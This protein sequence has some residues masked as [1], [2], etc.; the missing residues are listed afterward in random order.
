MVDLLDE[1]LTPLQ[2]P[3]LTELEEARAGAW[4]YR[5]R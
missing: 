1:D 4:S 5:R 2:A 3:T